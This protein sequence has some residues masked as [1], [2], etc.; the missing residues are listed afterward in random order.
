MPGLKPWWSS[1]PFR[2]DYPLAEVRQAIQEIIKLTPGSTARILIPEQTAEI[3]KLIA[4]FEEPYRAAITT[5][6]PIINRVSSQVPK[7]RERLQ[8]IGLFGYSRQVGET[9]LPRAIGFTAACYSL[10][11]PPEIIGTGRGLARAK[12]EGRL[13]IIESLY[14]G[15]R[16]A[17]KE[18]G[19]FLRPDSLTELGLSDLQTDLECIEE[20]LGDKLR[21]VN[22]RQRA[23]QEISGQIIAELGTGRGV[24]RLM[25]QAAKLRRSVG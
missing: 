14:P 17:L 22:Q 1:R 15:L 12:A 5:L 7:R 25:E 23:H 16:A 4:W 19:G 21:P 2:Y 3:K 6:A 18:A 10:G 8:H 24:S 9:K 20:Y 13:P 11:I